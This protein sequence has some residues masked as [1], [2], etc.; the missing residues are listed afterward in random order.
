MDGLCRIWCPRLQT[1]LRT[2]TQVG[3]NCVPALFAT[4]VPSESFFVAAYT[5]SSVKIFETCSDQILGTFSGAVTEL[6][7]P[8]VIELVMR[9][10][11]DPQV[12]LMMSCEDGFVRC[13]DFATQAPLWEF[14]VAEG[15]F[16]LRVTRE[17]GLM[18]VIDIGTNCLQIWKRISS[19]VA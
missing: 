5:D 7:M 2:Y 11:D 6:R 8:T 14:R 19:S 16:K 15:P 18:A 17:G 4:L 12:D 10:P 13:W 3:A 9:N 1:L